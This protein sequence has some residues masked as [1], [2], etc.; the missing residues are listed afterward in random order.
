MDNEEEVRVDAAKAAA[1]YVHPKLSAVAVRMTPARD[2]SGLSMEQLK[3][4]DQLLL[5]VVEM[6]AQQIAPA[7]EHEP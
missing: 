2:Y 6:D 3:L 4:L 1:P 5:H 7:I